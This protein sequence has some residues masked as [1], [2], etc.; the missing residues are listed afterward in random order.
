LFLVLLI[1]HTAYAARHAVL[2]RSR[3][4]S[5]SGIIV[6]FLLI[7]MN[8]DTFKSTRRQERTMLTTFAC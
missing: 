5:E 4:T 1:H 8:K 6:H 7:L 3:H 2:L